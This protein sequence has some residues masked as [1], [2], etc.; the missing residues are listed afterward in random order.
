MEELRI[1]VD[2]KPESPTKRKQEEETDGGVI[3]ASSK[4]NCEN[5]TDNRL[6]M[7]GKEKM[8]AVEQVS[9]GKGLTGF[10]CSHLFKL[11]IGIDFPSP[12]PS[13]CPGAIFKENSFLQRIP[14]MLCI[15]AYVSAEDS[16]VRL[17]L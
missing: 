7:K 6:R 17:L 13:L 11:P 8:T 5:G 15:N 10:V 4:T 16:S 3:K 1:I 2:D 12:I 9:I 14:A